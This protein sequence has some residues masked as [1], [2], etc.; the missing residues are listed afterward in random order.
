[1]SSRP[2]SR[3]IFRS[4]KCRI[5]TSLEIGQ[6]QSVLCPSWSL[7]PA[8]EWAET[9]Q[10][11]CG[12]GS[13]GSA[14]CLRQPGAAGVWPRCEHWVC[15]NVHPRGRW[16]S[17]G[18]ANRPSRHLIVQQRR[19]N[20]RGETHTI[21]RQ[22]ICVTRGRRAAMDYIGLTMG[23]R[24]FSAMRRFVAT[25]ATGDTKT[26]LMQLVDAAQ[27]YLELDFPPIVVV[28]G[29]SAGACAG[30]TTELA[31]VPGQRPSP[32]HQCLASN[33]PDSHANVDLGAGHHV[34]APAKVPLVATTTS[35][36]SASTPASPGTV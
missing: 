28:S 9:S 22:G 13:G 3:R 34:C 12:L 18:V 19:V 17:S 29:N 24:N 10:L 11:P 21:P 26:S 36:T 23:E 35:S 33:A 27:Q 20:L 7:S 16:T 14:K 32:C 2:P 4:L 6:R 25:A 8:P 15:N 5:C 31:L 1:M 30:H